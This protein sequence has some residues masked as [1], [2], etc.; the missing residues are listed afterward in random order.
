V[1]KIGSSAFMGCT[2]LQS[3]I[4][5]DGVTI[6]NSSVFSDCTAMT[7]VTIPRSVRTIDGLAFC[8]CTALNEIRYRGSIQE[9]NTIY[10]GTYWNEGV[11]AKTIIPIPSADDI[12]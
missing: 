3:V 9:W 6:L 12:N 11:P 7:S 8:N 10:K 5:P 2:S 4:I 1:K